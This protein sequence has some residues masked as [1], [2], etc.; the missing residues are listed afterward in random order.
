MSEG[1]L[2][3]AAGHPSDECA[4]ADMSAHLSKLAVEIAS[5]KAKLMEARAAENVARKHATDALNAFNECAREF[6]TVLASIRKDAPSNTDWHNAAH[7]RM[8]G[9]ASET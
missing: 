2:Y 3:N 7:P 8:T 5:R 9:F 1:K 6:D 4:K